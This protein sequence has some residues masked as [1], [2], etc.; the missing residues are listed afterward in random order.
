V[1]ILKNWVIENR[2]WPLKPAA[3]PTRAFKDDGKGAFLEFFLFNGR[4]CT[5]P[6]NHVP[7]F[8]VLMINGGEELWVERADKKGGPKNRNPGLD[9]TTAKPCQQI[10]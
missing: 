1:Q 3:H 9:Q 7:E 2:V 6:F 5:L 8:F 4:V 10:A